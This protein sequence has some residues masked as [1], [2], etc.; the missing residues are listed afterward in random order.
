MT[1]EDAGF[2][3]VPNVA[4]DTEPDPPYE[5]SGRRNDLDPL[6]VD[7]PMDGEDHKSQHQMLAASDLESETDS[8]HNRGVTSPMMEEDAGFIDNPNVADDAEFDPPLEQP[9]RRS[10]LQHGKHDDL[11]DLMEQEDDEAVA[12]IALPVGPES[13]SEDTGPMLHNVSGKAE[14]HVGRPPCKEL[15]RHNGLDTLDTEEPIDREDQMGRNETIAASGSGSK[16]ESAHPEG[17]TTPMLEEKPLSANNPNV[18]GDADLDPPYEQHERHNDLRC[19]PQQITNPPYVTDALGVEEPMEGKDQLGQH[20]T[21]AASDSGSDADSVHNRGAMSPMMEDAGFINTPNVADDTELDSPHEQP[22]K[23]IP[24]LDA[25]K[26]EESMEGEDQPGQHQTLAASDSGSDTD[27]VHN[28]GATSPMMEEDAGFIDIPNVADDTKLDPPYEQPGRRNDLDTID[29]EEPIEG[30]DQLG[31]HQTLAASDSESETD[32]VDNRGATSPMTEEDA[33]F[34]DVP[35][36]ADDTKPDPP[37]EQTGRRNDLDTLKVEESMEGEDQ[38]GQ[39]QTLAAN[40]LKV[41]ESMGGEDQLGQHQTLADSDSESDMDS[42]HNRARTSVNDSNV[43]K[44]ADLDSPHEDREPHNYSD[45]SLVDE[46]MAGED[47]SDQHE[48][49]AASDSES[50]KESNRNPSATP[51]LEEETACANNTELGPPYK[52]HGRPIDSEMLDEERHSEGQYQLGQHE[53]VTASDSDTEMESIHDQD[54]QSADEAVSLKN[55]DVASESDHELVGHDGP[56]AT[57]HK[58]DDDGACLEDSLKVAVESDFEMEAFPDHNLDDN[59][60]S[61]ASPCYSLPAAED[62]DSC[63]ESLDLANAADDSMDEQSNA[64]KDQILL[65]IDDEPAV[66]IRLRPVA[67]EADLD[68]GGDRRLILKVSSENSQFEIFDEYYDSVQHDNEDVVTLTRRLRAAMNASSP[69]SQSPHI[70]ITL[71]GMSAIPVPSI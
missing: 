5:Q 15:G 48:T 17:A 6:E 45:I 23:R 35:N 49:I 27:S 63:D 33:G 8:I 66:S 37:Y 13:D 41:K 40:S 58:L 4:D 54:A 1:E 34:V 21:L 2:V 39:H 43:A 14:C 46:P 71:E 61:P 59:E 32:S 47:R 62:S 55:L 7:E 57:P 3:D 53:P 38:L 68:A 51:V 36:V 65:M 30:K 10:D 18:T 20:K 69:D 29:V 16:T 56:E 22:G 70:D 31:Q 19:Y 9:G 64:V 50:D 44:D 26:V 11:E 28:R 25:L 60:A 24:D 12:R 42:I 67:Q 52:Q